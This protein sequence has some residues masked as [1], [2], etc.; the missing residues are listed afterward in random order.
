MSIREPVFAAWRG[1]PLSE[2]LFQ[3]RDAIEEA[4]FSMVTRWREGGGKVVGHF[5]VYFPT[6]LAHAAGML[7]LKMAGAPIEAN[8]AESRFGSY[9]CSILKSSLELSLSG[10]VKLD[11]FV[12]HPICDAARNLAAIW[13]R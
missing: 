11:L 1:Q 3:C 12:S 7:P 2:I 10:R 4:D 9:L 8:N 6:E 5:Q 13:G